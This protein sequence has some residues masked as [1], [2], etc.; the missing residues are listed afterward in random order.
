MLQYMRGEA[1]SQFLQCRGSPAAKKKGGAI[2]RAARLLALH[3][4]KGP[5][6]VLRQYR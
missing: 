6:C 2:A 3:H 4:P 5:T 1:A